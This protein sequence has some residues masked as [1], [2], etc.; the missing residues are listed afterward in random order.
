MQRSLNFS[1][2]LPKVSSASAA[3][4]MPQCL[5][6]RLLHCAEVIEGQ[7]R[8]TA[9]IPFLLAFKRNLTL[10]HRREP[11]TETDL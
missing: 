5:Q 10:R 9:L 7:A 4:W 1:H 11:L 8:A 2:D 3:D 6:R